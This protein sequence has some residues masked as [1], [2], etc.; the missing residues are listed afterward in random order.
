MHKG[1]AAVHRGLLLDWDPDIGRVGVQG[2]AEEA[3]RRDADDRK[4]MLLDRERG[5]DDSG[6]GPINSLPGT[7]TQ[8]GGGRGG[9]SIVIGGDQPAAVGTY[10][11]GRKVVAGDVFGS[12]RR[13][14]R[15]TLTADVHPAPSG[16]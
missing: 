12:E 1:A 10:A 5:A 13:A 2:V 9:G 6:I 14:A 11:Q 4:R 3:G 7:V 16:L 15:G 8:D